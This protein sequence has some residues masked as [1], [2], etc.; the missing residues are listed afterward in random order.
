MTYWY[1]S[2]LLPNEWAGG[3]LNDKEGT[4]LARWCICRLEKAR[5][6]WDSSQIEFYFWM[7]RLLT[8][9]ADGMSLL[10]KVFSFTITLQ[11]FLIWSVSRSSE[12][13]GVFEVLI[14]FPLFL[15]Y[16]LDVHS[17]SVGVGVEISTYCDFR[18]SSLWRQT[19][20]AEYLEHILHH[21][22]TRSHWLLGKVAGILVFIL[23]LESARIWWRS[24][25]LWREIYWEYG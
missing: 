4:W 21:R 1:R 15:L 2:S 13:P 19:D 9:T 6:L 8:P 14:F 24:R 5:S 11:G 20:L 12:W 3:F 23:V 22:Y 16:M 10:E 18:P 7:E 25:Q 17:C